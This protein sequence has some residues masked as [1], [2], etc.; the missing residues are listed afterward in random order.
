MSIVTNNNYKPIPFIVVERKFRLGKNA[1]KVLKVAHPTRRKRVSFSALAEETAQNITLSSNELQA[2]LNELAITAKRHLSNGDSVE[3]GIFGTLTPS[4]KSKAVPQD[5][6]FHAQTNIYAPRIKF[7][8]NRVYM[9]LEGVTFERV[10]TT[11]P[12]EKKEHSS[13]APANTEAHPKPE[14]SST[15]AHNNSNPSL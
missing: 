10:T 3:L 15:D 11:N 1:G 14:G 2:A 8:G 7:R 9:N 4:F 12:K 6:E 13:A 5:T